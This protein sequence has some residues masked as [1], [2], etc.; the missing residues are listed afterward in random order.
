MSIDPLAMV[1]HIANILVLYFG[2]KFL[3]YK[4]IRKFMSD[5]TERIQDALNEAEKVKAEAEVKIESAALAQREADAKLVEMTNAGVRAGQEHGERLITQ[6]RVTAN[7][8]INEAKR[9]AEQIMLEAHAKL[10]LETVDLAVQIAGKILERE[11]GPVDEAALA[12]TL[13]EKVM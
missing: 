5:R 6:A 7:G 2:V 13:I 1:W 12:N 8:I 11:I 4:R 10:R 3:L 9:D